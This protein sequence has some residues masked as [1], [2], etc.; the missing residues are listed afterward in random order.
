M[1]IPLESQFSSTEESE[2]ACFQTLFRCFE[3]IRD[4]H[5]FQTSQKQQSVPV[6]YVFF[7]A[8]CAYIDYTEI[9]SSRE[10]LRKKYEEQQNLNVYRFEQLRTFSKRFLTVSISLPQDTK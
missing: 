6:L 10:H 7:R 8:L 4:Y 1:R 5:S 3:I 2:M 9:V